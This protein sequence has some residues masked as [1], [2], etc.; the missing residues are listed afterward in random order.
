[1]VGRKGRPRPPRRVAAA[2]SAD[3]LMDRRR[4]R[5]PAEAWPDL[6]GWRVN[7]ERATYEVAYSVDAVPAFWSGPRRN[8]TRAIPPVRPPLGP[9]PDRAR[10]TATVSDPSFTRAM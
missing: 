4:A 6:A 9:P 1:M 5:D 8:H 3:W 7:Y 10:S 2:V